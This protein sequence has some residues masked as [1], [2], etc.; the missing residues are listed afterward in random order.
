MIITDF[1]IGNA[2][3]FG[4][5]IL[6][7]VFIALL[8]Y[9][10][11]ELLSRKQ[12]I[13]LSEEFHKKSFAISAAVVLGWL[14]YLLIP[15]EIYLP[16]ETISIKFVFSIFMVV[17][18]FQY[19]VFLLTNLVSRAKTVLGIG[20]GAGLI[21]ST[22]AVSIW[23]NVCADNPDI[24]HEGAAS[25]MMANTIMV[26]RNFVIVW[27][28]GAMMGLFIIPPTTFLAPMLAMFLFCAAI[29]FVNI[30][31]GAQ[32][33]ENQEIE[34]FSLKAIGIFMAI[35]I[36]M[37]YLAIALI[38]KFDFVGLYILSGIAAFLYGS[39]HLFI[40]ASLLM[41]HAISLEVALIA[42]VIVTAGS[43]LSDIPY[44]YVA[45]AI[46][47]VKLLLISEIIP[48]VIGIATLIYLI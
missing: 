36:V 37:Y 28:V 6:F 48:V 35:F 30:R 27:I 41:T 25:V 3:I 2:N 16:L 31:L 10:A 39:A 45:G 8:M 1:F 43:I 7:P 24:S 21:R 29:S 12:G 19:I 40:I 26:L 33:A 42:G 14:V 34:T 44:A 22:L 15:S 18:S 46:D 47:L 9:I 13:S 5:Y 11:T 17:L 20:A 23:A 38:E 4:R 32:L